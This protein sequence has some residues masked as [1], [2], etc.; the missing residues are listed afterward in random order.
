MEYK[1]VVLGAGRQG[2]AAAYD[3]AMRGS[4]ESIVLADLD[5]NTA[6]NAAITVN[7]LVGKNIAH[8]AR[9]DATRLETVTCRIG[10][11]PRSIK[12][13]AVFL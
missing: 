10:R 13:R 3:L 6:E 8:P 11:S 2:T 5:L 4:A 9:I 1:Y 7:N 12:R